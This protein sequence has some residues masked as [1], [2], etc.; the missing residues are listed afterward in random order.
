MNIESLPES[1]RT[2]IDNMLRLEGLLPET[3][4]AICEPQVL[5]LTEESLRFG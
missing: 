1:Y 2:A 4:A 3:V 5:F